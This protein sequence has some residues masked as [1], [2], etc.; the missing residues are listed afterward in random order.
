MVVFAPFCSAARALVR[1]LALSL[2]SVPS[3][4]GE[5]FVFVCVRNKQALNRSV[6][7]GVSVRVCSKEGSCDCVSEFVLRNGMFALFF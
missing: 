5:V 6:F 3:C 4:E 2:S 1:S 7:V